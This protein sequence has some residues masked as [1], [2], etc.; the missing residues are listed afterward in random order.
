MNAFALMVD[1]Q[2]EDP[3]LGLDAIW[4]AGG[5]DSGPSVRIRRRTPEAITGLH[6]NQFDLDAMLIDIRLSEVA[7]PAENDEIDLLDDDG[8]IIETL[9][10][11]GMASIDTRR[12]VRTCEVAPKPPED[13]AP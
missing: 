5:G 12:L 11:T 4:R 2:F 13:E 7:A 1:A 9:V 8:A 6:G 10:V 3:N